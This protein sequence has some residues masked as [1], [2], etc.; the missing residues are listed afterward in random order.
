LDPVLDLA[1]VT[2]LRGHR[3]RDRLNALEHHRYPDDAWHE[4]GCEGRLCRGPKPPDALADLRENEQENKAQQERL[5]QGAQ[6]ELPPVLA[7]HEQVARNERP[8]RCP[9]R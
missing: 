4:D 7:Q 9:A 3:E 8:E 6:H 1:C 2:E 5:D